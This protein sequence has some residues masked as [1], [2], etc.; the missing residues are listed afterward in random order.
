MSKF[1]RKQDEETQHLNEDTPVE[2]VAEIRT[3]HYDR[4]HLTNRG[5]TRHWLKRLGNPDL[6]LLTNHKSQTLPTRFWHRDRVHL[7]E[8][9][10]EWS[11]D[12]RLNDAYALTKYGRGLAATRLA[13][14]SMGATPVTDTGR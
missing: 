13:R 12:R 11:L 2:V 10:T 7:M 1:A 8:A 6:T 9:T 5:W 4:E 3:T 14:L